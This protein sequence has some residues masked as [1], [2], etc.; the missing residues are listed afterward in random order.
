MSVYCHGGIL[1]PRIS[2]YQNYAVLKYSMINSSY[3]IDPSRLSKLT[4]VV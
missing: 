2:S 4:P 3:D 1:T